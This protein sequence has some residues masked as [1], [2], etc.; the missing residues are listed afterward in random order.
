MESDT[1]LSRIRQCFSKSFATYDS[2]AVAQRLI[3]H[4]LVTLLLEQGYDRCGELLEIGCGTGALTRELKERLTV[5]R[6]T[7]NDLCG[8]SG[9]YL[10]RILGNG[11]YT[12]LCGD[13]SQLATDR[14]YDMIASASVFQWIEDQPAFFRRLSERLNAGGV[15]AFSTFDPDNMYEVKSLTGKGLRY[16]SQEELSASLRPWFEIERIVGEEIPLWFKSPIEVLR[17]LKLTG[18]TATGDGTWTRGKQENFV[19]NYK[20]RYTNSN[21]ECHLTYTPVFVVA[22]KK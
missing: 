19:N 11:G 6:W 3:C 7:L 14:R 10:D 13:A 2:N 12:F 21:G 18:V 20:I 5:E 17:H 8:E 16:A 1:E 4:R 9:I 15:L 22:K